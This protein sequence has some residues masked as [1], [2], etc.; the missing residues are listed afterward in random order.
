MA[1]KRDEIDLDDIAVALK[2]FG[3]VF[4]EKVTEGAKTAAG[5]I[6]E[7]GAEAAEI[8]QESGADFSKTV[9]E[10]ANRFIERAGKQLGKTAKLT[11]VVAK[12]VIA[13]SA[14]ATK[15]YS[16]LLRPLAP[17]ERFELSKV[18]NYLTEGELGMITNWVKQGKARISLHRHGWSFLI[19]GK[20]HFPKIISPEQFAPDINEKIR[21]GFFHDRF[22]EFSDRAFAAISQYIAPDIIGNFDAKQAI[23]L[24]LFSTE[25]YNILLVGDQFSGK[26]ELMES[27]RRLFGS[28]VKGKANE[29]VCVMF[30]EQGRVRPGFLARQV[31]GCFV[32]KLHYIRKEDELILYRTLETSYI[33]YKTKKGRRRFDV[34]ASILSDT[35]PKEDGKIPLDPYLVGKFHLTLFPKQANL[36]N[37][38]DIA[39]KI[40]SEHK[41]PIRDADMDFIKKYVSY[42]LKIKEVVIPHDLGE[43]IKEFATGVKNREPA[44]PYKITPQIVVGIVRMAKASARMELRKS[45]EAKDLDRVF[46]I[47]DKATKIN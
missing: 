23:M 27:A 31:S 15:D 14:A 26:A 28:W 43:K 41:V 18:A 33:S 7:K 3:K 12:D 42:A 11:A 13:K 36:Q 45:V 4:S 25:P 8:L 9:S 5:I 46:R 10:Q 22:A 47:Y 29:G 21:K 35:I 39:E 1:G 20:D 30:D 2:K 24:Q 44:L 16:L 32:T 37:F 38:S 19:S 40:V 6:K 17:R 34:R